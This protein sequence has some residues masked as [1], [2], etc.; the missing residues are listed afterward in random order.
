MMYEH[1]MRV[2]MT[3]NDNKRGCI[4]VGGVD[5]TFSANNTKVP[6][7]RNLSIGISTYYMTIKANFKQPPI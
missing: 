4:I 1:I 5:P 2:G 6:N 7:T 3:I